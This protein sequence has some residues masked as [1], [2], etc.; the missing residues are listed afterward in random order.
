MVV[1]DSAGGLFFG[2]KSDESFG[3]SSGDFGDDIGLN[4]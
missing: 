3:A 4:F 1:R 2:G